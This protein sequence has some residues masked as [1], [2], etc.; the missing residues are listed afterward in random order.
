MYLNLQRTYLFLRRDDG[1][2]SKYYK[3]KKRGK[4]KK[5]RVVP[6]EVFILYLIRQR[7]RAKEGRKETPYVHI[8]YLIIY[9]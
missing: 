6:R 1:D 4:G 2:I 3:K 5:I 8:L 7:E 9:I